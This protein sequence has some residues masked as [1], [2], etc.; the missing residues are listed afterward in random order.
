LIKSKEDFSKE[1]FALFPNL[2]EE[3]SSLAYGFEVDD[4]YFLYSRVRMSFATSVLEFGSGWSTLALA[5]GLSEN[6]QQVGGH[7]PHRHPNAF[8]LMTVDASESWQKVALNRLGAT[9][10]SFV[11]P[12]VSSCALVR[13]E[14]G[15]ILSNF[16]NVPNFSPDLIYIDAP[17]PEQVTGSSGGFSFLELHSLPQ[18][19]NILEIEYQ[20]WPGTEVVLDGRTSNARMLQ[21]LLKRRWD[22]F[23]DP[24][25]D[26]THLR[27]AEEPFGEL[28]RNHFQDRLNHSR[29]LVQK[30]GMVLD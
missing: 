22:F 6:A 3:D 27:L 5:L 15:L 11:V 7:W 8:V 17:D 14:N 30:D 28:S 26:R 16:Q 1:I 10:K 20:L 4:L 18:V 29:F 24:F 19:G 12:V 2:E 21:G 25:G 23:F 9:L 13:G